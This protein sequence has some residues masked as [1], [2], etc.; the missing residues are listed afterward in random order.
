MLCVM[1][2]QKHGL[3]PSDG[4]VLVPGAA[5]GVGSFANTL[6]GKFG[7]TVAASTG[8]MTEADYLKKLGATEVI[9]RATLSAPGRPLAK[10]RWAAVVDS[11]GSHTLA[12]ACAQTK[13]DGAVAACGL[14]L[15]KLVALNTLDEISQDISLEDSIKYAQDL[16]AGN[17]RGRLIVDV[18][19]QENELDCTAALEVCASEVL[20]KPQAWMPPK[21]RSDDGKHIVIRPLAYVPEKLL[22][23]YA[24]DMNFPIIPCDL[25]GSQP[26]L[27]RLQSYSD[28]TNQQSQRARDSS[29]GSNH[30]QD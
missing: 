26:N 30:F 29:R 20:T 27:Q 17:V 10:E 15:A 28:Q 11:V 22:E 14:E 13:S 9:D 1:A 19:K 2:L 23:R 25:C 24:G 16:M 7:F 18:N 21:L 3:K 5:G 4:E 6:L 8:R 12:N